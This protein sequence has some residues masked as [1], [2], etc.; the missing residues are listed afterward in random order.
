MFWSRRSTGKH[1]IYIEGSVEF[2]VIAAVTRKCIIFW[3]LSPYIPV[4]GHQFAQ[5]LTVSFFRAEVQAKQ[6]TSR[7]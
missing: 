6:A 5:E 4:A 2:E 7:T 1:A 3:D